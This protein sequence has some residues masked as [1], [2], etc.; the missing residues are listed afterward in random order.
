MAGSKAS[1]ASKHGVQPQSGRSTSSGVS[2]S[3]GKVSRSAGS[4]SPN[5][6]DTSPKKSGYD[7]I[8][9]PPTKIINKNIDFGVGGWDTVLGHDI[10]SIPSRQKP[11]TLGQ[12]TSIGL[13]VFNVTARPND[14]IYQYDVVIGSGAE[15]RGL[16]KKVWNSKEIQSQLGNSFIFDGNRLAWSMKDVEREMRIVVDLDAEQ[17]RQPRPGKENKHRIMIRRTHKI[18]FDVMDQYLQGKTSFDTSILEAINFLD[19][20][21]R[22]YPSKRYTAIKRSF[23]AR[24]EQRFDLG[25]GVEAFKGVYQSM[26][27]VHGGTGSPARLTINLDVANGMF[28]TESVLMNTAAKLCGARDLSDLSNLLS[29][30]EKGSAGQALKKLRKVHVVA[31]HRGGQPDELVIDN[32]V[33]K[34]ARD[35]KF[36]KDGKMISIYDY[37]AKQY[38]I[39]L[40]YP[41]LPLVKATRGK[42]TIIP[43]EVLKI[44][45]N[46]RY[47]YKLEDFQTVNMIKFAV[48]PPVQRWSAIE[49][50][51]EMLNWANDPVLKAFGLKI[52]RKNSVVDA[53]IIPAPT[54]KFGTGEAKPGTSGRW[55]LKGKKFLQPNVTPLKSWAVCVIPGRRGGKPDKAVIETFIKEFVKIYQNHGGRVENRQPA[56]SLAAGDDVSKWVTAAWNAAGN[57]VQSR[58]QILVFILPD[59]DS[60]VYGRIKR[61]CECRYGV[62]SQCMQYANVQKCQAQ[63]ISNVCMKF[64]AK[65]GGTTCR[66]VGSKSGG[67]NGIFSVPTMV[68]GADVSHAAPGTQTASMAAITI[69]LDKLATRYAAVCQT[70]GFR[71]EMVKTEILT[72][73]LKPMVQS[74]IQN[75]GGGKL[76]S[77]IFYFRDGVSEGQYHQVL[78]SEVKDLKELMRSANPGHKVEFLVVVGSKRHSV[79]FFPNKGGDRN[80][81]ALPGTLVETGVTHPFENDFY[82]CSHAAIKGTARPMHYYVLLNEPK[83]PNEEIQT[84][85]YEHSYQYIRATTPV[86]QHPAMYYAHIASN[87]AGPHNPKWMGSSESDP[88]GEQ[89]P[90]ADPQEGSQSPRP[91]SVSPRGGPPSPRPASGSGS[92]P[93]G[94]DQLGGQPVGSSTAAQYDV[95]KLM[96]MPNQGGLVTSMWYI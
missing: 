12:P 42:N 89:Q 23:F 20:L 84:L 25:G 91:G 62:I 82:L 18:R 85:L 64:N 51:L 75:V 59:K 10:T 47:A 17:G 87:R 35:Y 32:F 22:E 1:S 26:R 14:P 48:Q 33:Y 83:M 88:S 43:M 49:H 13:N 3:S 95:P 15:K 21:L 36:E 61:S 56:M 86:S 58:P 53:R 69:S 60:K 66:A 63:Y 16:I 4:A 34:S 24:G 46:E 52:D 11:S 6:S 8:D 94:G 7:G 40:S 67:L 29:R 76:P 65:L 81:N 79:R 71:T 31:Q 50:G 45:P 93:H 55:D 68:I 28:W 77:R 30:G 37:F 38:N 70:N 19:H 74:W 44:M 27:I 39:R 5:K 2:S 92:P 54:V 78:A 90:Q 72:E 96:P 41:N 9:D 80:G 57:Q 73:E